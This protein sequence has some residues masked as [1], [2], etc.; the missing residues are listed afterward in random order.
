MATIQP[1]L[2]PLLPDSDG[3]EGLK[4]RLQEL[5]G[6]ADAVFE[7]LQA[8]INS[9][10][11]YHVVVSSTGKSSMVTY[12]AGL[13]KQNERHYDPR[14]ALWAGLSRFHLSTTP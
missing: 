11:E 14:I 2:A 8:S 1:R 5:N 4:A 9:S 13:Y 10:S 12:A 7:E 3:I 6:E